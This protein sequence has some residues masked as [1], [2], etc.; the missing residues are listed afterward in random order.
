MRKIPYGQAN[1]ADIRKRNQ[2]YVDKTRFLSLMEE[3]G[4]YLMLIRPRRMGKSLWV[5][6]MEAYYDIAWKGMFEEWFGN[7]EI[8]K[9]PTEERNTYLIMKF[10]FSRIESELQQ[11]QKS[12]HSYISMIT[13]M[14]VRKYK[15]YFDDDSF[16]E[17]FHR[18]DS[19]LEQ[20]NLI[21]EEGLKNGLK[22]YLLVDEYDNFTNTDLSA[23]GTVSYKEI[24]RG[25]GFYRDFFKFFKGGTNVLGEGRIR[26]F[27]TGVS[28]VTLDDLT[29]GANNI[30]NISLSPSFNELFGF[31]EEEVQ[32]LLDYYLQETQIELDP[33]MLLATMRDWYN[34][35][36]F[37]DQARQDMYNTDMVLHFLL[38]MMDEQRIPQELIDHN[39]RIGYQKLRH[40]LLVDSQHTSDARLNGNFSLL[41]EVIETGKS[42]GTVRTSFP[43]DQIQDSD[44][45]QSLLYYF[46]LLTFGEA[47]RG[48]TTLRIPNQVVSKLMYGYL[49]DGLR[50]VGHFRIDPRKIGNLVEDM[51]YDGNWKA[52]FTMLSQ[53]IHKQTSIRD[54]FS[55]E[56]VVQGFLLAYLNLT[57]VFLTYSEY[58]CSKGYADLYLAPFHTKYPNLKYGYLIELKYIPRKMTGEAFNDKLLQLKAEAHSQLKQYQQDSHLQEF[59]ESNRTPDLI[60]L[61][62]IFHGWE[63]V[64]LEAV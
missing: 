26:L 35:Y 3:S 8:G 42:M 25:S 17:E 41:K 56:R 53:E 30:R 45:F 19:G 20:L 40:L 47:D 48:R 7:L 37:S 33:A 58:E 63:L 64:Y 15:T 38:S 12:F 62:L 59:Y 29:S 51:A 34:H 39:I 14:F 28:P 52:F 23:H 16:L 1:F 21:L 44:N 61:I 4:D 57:D 31:T 55:A 18:L 36:R 5:S 43:I 13:R 22:I 2:M 10:D 27:M 32:A 50:E 9:N 24:T 6:I 46:G 60:S 49:R 11:V 54:Y